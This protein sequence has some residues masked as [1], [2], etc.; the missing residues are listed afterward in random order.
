MSIHN[1]VRFDQNCTTITLNALWKAW[2]AL[3][4]AF[5]D[6]NAENSWFEDATDIKH[7]TSAFFYKLRSSKDW[8]H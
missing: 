1:F 3:W 4:G 5:A 8:G 7:T 2:W 6:I